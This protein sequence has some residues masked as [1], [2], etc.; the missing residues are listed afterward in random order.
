[1]LLVFELL[2]GAMLGLFI[3]VSGNPFT[4]TTLY[5]TLLMFSV[6][7]SILLDFQTLV[8]APQDYVRL[9]PYP[10]SARTFFAARLTT[11]VAYVTA[12]AL[13]IGA[14]PLLGLFVVGGFS[15]TR[16]GGGLI[17]TV[18][19]AVTVA[20]AVVAVY[21]TV[22]TKLSPA[23]ARR[24]LDFV[25]LAMSFVL[26]GSW[27][28]LNPAVQGRLLPADAVHLPSWFWLNPAAWFAS[29]PFVAAGAA[30]APQGWAAGG[31]LLAFLAMTRAIAGRLSLEYAAKL[32]EL[33][34]TSPP[35]AT[36]F[37]ARFFS[38]GE[39]RAVALLIGAQFR[40]EKRFRLAV[41]GILP[42]T[43]IYLLMSLTGPGGSRDQHY[44]VFYAALM[45]PTM[46]YFAVQRSDTWRASWSFYASPSDA[47]RLVLAIRSFVV[48][49]FL[50]PYLI[51]VTAVI[52]FVEGLSLQLARTAVMLALASHALL[53][54][55]MAIVPRLP[56]AAPATR[57]GQTR[58]V[59][60]AVVVISFLTA[61]LPFLLSA[62]ATAAHSLFSVVLLL[63][64]NAALEWLVHWRV[65]R[66]MAGV[67]FTG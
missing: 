20:F 21:G 45:F 58:D 51:L 38:Q 9:A 42:L 41:L 6:G 40:H 33:E 49:A 56:F 44:L 31:A 10:I 60:A 63:A 26:Y 22:M 57:G 2:L 12:I 11:L 25:Q 3:V 18:L 24:A 47:A 7:S 15:V 1:M 19:A 59:M 27:L 32:A 37:L 23:R 65:T 46:L 4:A 54:V 62:S 17:A 34:T 48:I 39:A 50:A 52:A 35:S 30:G 55:D 29:I 14:F 5:V 67:E 64:V 13:A 16:A 36:V 28:L 66:R 43:F 61:L 53:L 8:V